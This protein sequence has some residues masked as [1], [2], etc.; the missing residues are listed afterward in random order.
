MGEGGL[1]GQYFIHEA[2]PDKPL[3]WQ[4]GILHWFPQTGLRLMHIAG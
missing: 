3:R 1:A 2:A 4:I